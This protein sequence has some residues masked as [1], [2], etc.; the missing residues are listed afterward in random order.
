MPELVASAVLLSVHGVKR[1]CAVRRP[2]NA[3]DAGKSTRGLVRPVMV[4]KYVKASGAAPRQE[5]VVVEDV[6]VAG[7]RRAVE[8]AADFQSI[9]CSGV[10]PSIEHVS[11][12][13][14]ILYAANKQQPLRHGEGLVWPS[15]LVRHIVGD[16]QVLHR[17]LVSNRAS[18]K[19]D[20]A[21]ATAC[22]VG[23]IRDIAGPNDRVR[24][25]NVVAAIASI[26][27]R[28]TPVC[29]LNAKTYVSDGVVSNL[30]RTRAVNLYA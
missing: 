12:E 26:A 30:A 25:D 22:T 13:S 16:R 2:A 11:G 20:G 8:A 17:G 18:L 6:V 29:D 5:R 23:A 10:R 27:L 21:P 19:L 4:K 7:V 14:S 15:P 24:V 3:G 1:I 28:R 9:R